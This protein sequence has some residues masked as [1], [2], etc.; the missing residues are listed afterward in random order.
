MTRPL[1][2]CIWSDDEDGYNASGVAQRAA[3]R[4]HCDRTVPDV[5]LRRVLEPGRLKLLL[6]DALDRS[7][8]AERRRKDDL[9]RVRRERIAV[10][11]R[12]RR[13]LELG[14]GLMSPRDP[15][16]GEKLAEGPSITALT[17]TERS[18]MGQL[19]AGGRIIGDAAVERSGI[20]PKTEI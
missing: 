17:E 8:D 16:C 10:E 14:E 9:D 13:V 20:M 12:L 15:I 2:A 1:R 18:L 11:T 19:G 3:C 6:A 4:A 5:L 7:D